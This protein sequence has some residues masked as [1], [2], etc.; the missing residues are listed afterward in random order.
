M[1][2]KLILQDELLDF[3]IIIA[4]V[5]HTFCSLTTPMVRNVDSAYEQVQHLPTTPNPLTI[6]YKVQQCAQEVFLT[7]CAK[8][9]PVTFK[10]V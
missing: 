1:N 3:F 10:K 4:N 7:T 8:R 9:S 6:K 2:Y 5:S